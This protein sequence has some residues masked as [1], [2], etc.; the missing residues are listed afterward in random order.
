MSNR[1]RE[2]SA[3]FTV[4]AV[5]R[6]VDVL[7]FLA[8]KQRAGVTQIAEALGVHKSTAFRLVNALAAR[9]LVEQRELRGKYCLGFELIRLGGAKRLQPDTITLAN[10]ICEALAEE[11]GETV[12]IAVSDDGMAVNIA[13][14]RGLAGVITQNWMGRRTPLHATASGKVLLAFTP[15]RERDDLYA[16]GLDEFTPATVTDV[17]ALEEELA[18]IASQGYGLASEELE[19]GLNAAAAPVRAADGTVV[20]AVSAS[21][22]SYR[23]T[24]ERLPD[25][26]KS[27]IDAATEISW[28]LGFLPE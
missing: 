5:D 16:A 20:F 23:L 14:V 17:A 11:V 24:P 2:T 4:Q 9:G 10:P 19:V 27:V 28:L 21:G 12:N 1:S 13:Q 7:E 8:R 3:T 18:L 22:P 25:V 6:A 26:A 15:S